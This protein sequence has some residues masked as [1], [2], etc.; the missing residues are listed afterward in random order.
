MKQLLF[1]LLLIAS[2]ALACGDQPCEPPPPPPPPPPTQPPEVPTPP[3]DGDTV[4]SNYVRQYYSICTCDRFRVAW[5]FE[6]QEFREQAAR[7]Q[8]LILREKKHCQITDP[9]VIIGPYK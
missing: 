4:Y 6:T 3:N 8:C 2:P 7:A 1:L 5:G 9:D